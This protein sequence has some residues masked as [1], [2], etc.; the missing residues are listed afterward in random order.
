[1]TFTRKNK[2]TCSLSTT[3]TLE[4][5]IIRGVQFK[6]GC[7]GNLKGIARLCVGMKAADAIEKLRD[8]RCGRKQTSCPAQ[9]A[10]AL[11]EALR[12]ENDA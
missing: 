2:G 10:L 4:D 8:I 6:D 3:V 1:M 7:D 5:G 11:E 12:S 9:L